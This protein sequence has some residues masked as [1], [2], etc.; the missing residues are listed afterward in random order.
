VPI[1]FNTGLMNAVLPT[2]ADIRREMEQLL[3]F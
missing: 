2:V 1:P 3:H